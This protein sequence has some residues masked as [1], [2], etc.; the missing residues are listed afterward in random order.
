MGREIA[1]CDRE[2][3]RRNIVPGGNQLDFALRAHCAE[4]QGTG[5]GTR[6][7][8]HRRG[9]PRKLML[10]VEQEE[11]GTVPKDR[12]EGLLISRAE[13]RRVTVQLDHRA[14]QCRDHFLVRDDHDR[15]LGH[16]ATRLLREWYGEIPRIRSYR[17]AYA[18][19]HMQRKHFAPERVEWSPMSTA[20]CLV[21]TIG[22]LMP[23]P[24]M[25]SSPLPRDAA[26]IL[27]PESAVA[28]RDAFRQ[29]LAHRSPSA[30]DEVSAALGRV[31]VEARREQI[32]AERLLVAF[33]SIWSALP[34]VRQMPPHQAAD[35][36]RDLVSLCIERYYAPE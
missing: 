9:V 17:K 33:K 1:E 12:A 3:E 36:V 34:E 22:I 31:C 29:H 5:A 35:E 30:A 24:T 32:P 13:D 15:R 14:E 21:R 8:A 6:D 19:G 23:T 20:S 7:A 11:L 26:E 28:L 2:H 4:Q 18:I 25:S 16:D 10:A 27:S